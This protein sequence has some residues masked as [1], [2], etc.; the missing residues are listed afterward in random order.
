M[1]DSDIKTYLSAEMSSAG[2][3]GGRMSTNQVVHGVVNNVLPHVNKATRAAG[4]IGSE[5]HR[6]IFVK[7]ADGRR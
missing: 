4:N 3:N 7:A 5:L 1:L 2:T 6:K